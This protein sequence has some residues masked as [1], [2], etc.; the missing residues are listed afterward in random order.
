M[1]EERV[2]EAPGL[3][4]LTEYIES[5]K[6]D[7]LDVS[8]VPAGKVISFKTLNTQ[9]HFLVTDPKTYGGIMVGGRYFET[10]QP[11]RIHGSKVPDSAMIANGKIQKQL[12]L[13]IGVDTT[14]SSTGTIDTSNIQEIYISDDKSP[15]A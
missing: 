5:E 9:Y 14:I 7:G 1:E 13:E 8:T 2:H 6:G 10:P 15:F 11:A 4:A 3:D 12:V